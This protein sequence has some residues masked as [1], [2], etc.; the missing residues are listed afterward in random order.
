[1]VKGYSLPKDNIP[2]ELVD[3]MLIKHFQCLPS[4][5]DEEDHNRLMRFLEFDSM[6]NAANK[7]VEETKNRKNGRKY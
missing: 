3:Y 5:L 4:Q 7:K 1:M 2:E 6:I